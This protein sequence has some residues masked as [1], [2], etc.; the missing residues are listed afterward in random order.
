MRTDAG[1]EVAGLKEKSG[2][3][4]PETPLPCFRSSPQ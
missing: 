4:E 3:F 2:G 1:V